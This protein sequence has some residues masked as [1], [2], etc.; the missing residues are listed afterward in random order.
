MALQSGDVPA[1]GWPWNRVAEGALASREP[2]Y[3]SRCP[4]WRGT[5]WLC[6]MRLTRERGRS[7]SDRGA[8]ID[9]VGTGYYGCGRRVGQKDL[10]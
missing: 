2:S 7:L 8:W 9:G 6:G 4:H 10:N 5:D 3:R 1:Q